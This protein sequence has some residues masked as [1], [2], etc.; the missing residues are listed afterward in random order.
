MILLGSQ[1]E[2]L[3]PL[4]ALAS[5]T[6]CP[7]GTQATIHIQIG[8]TEEPQE[9]FCFRRAESMGEFR[10]KRRSSGNGGKAASS[11]TYVTW[12]ISRNSPTFLPPKPRNALNWPRHE[13]LSF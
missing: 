4:H 8:V 9:R 1:T 12:H 3:M 5:I 7:E 11:G 6:R 2:L 10:L 13:E